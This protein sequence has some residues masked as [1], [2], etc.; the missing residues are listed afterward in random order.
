MKL[1]GWAPGNRLRVGSFT[2]GVGQETKSE[3]RANGRVD[4]RRKRRGTSA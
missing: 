2:A 1:T 4:E 3:N